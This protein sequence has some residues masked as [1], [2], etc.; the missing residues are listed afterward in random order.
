[1]LAKPPPRT[2]DNADGSEGRVGGFPLKR[3]PSTART[4][5]PALQHRNS[6]SPLALLLSHPPQP[7]GSSP[8]SSAHGRGR[9]EFSPAGSRA[10]GWLRPPRAEARPCRARG[11]PQK[12]LDSGRMLS[13]WFRS[14]V[15]L[16][17]WFSF[18]GFSFAMVSS[19]SSGYYVRFL[20]LYL[21]RSPLLC[22]S[23]YVG[24]GGA[25]DLCVYK[26]SLPPLGGGLHGRQ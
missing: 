26:R 13:L 16:A 8:C 20:F 6:S 1:V 19:V 14:M 24:F 15:L 18:C 12:T 5:A 4:H 3:D 7:P 9:E 25:E 21:R 2:E 11:K 17:R 23:S 10:E 22:R